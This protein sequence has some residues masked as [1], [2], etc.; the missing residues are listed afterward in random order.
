MTK[1]NG[2]RLWYGLCR[3]CSTL[4]TGAAKDVGFCSRKCSSHGTTGREGRPLGYC[5][6]TDRG[7]ILIKVGIWYPGANSDGWMYEHRL[8][9]QEHMG[10]L[11]FPYELV[12]HKNGN[13]ADNGIG[14]LELCVKGQ[15]PPGV[16]IN[17]IFNTVAG[18]IAKRCHMKKKEAMKIVQEEFAY[19]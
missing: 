9:M 14:N 4:L 18:R 3:C 15:H 1:I 11:L 16:R 19:V 2:Y 17:D 10:R 12:H 7:Y 13:K 6:I 8:A 5:R